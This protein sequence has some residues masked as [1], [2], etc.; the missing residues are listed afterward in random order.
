MER[1]GRESL[2]RHDWRPMRLR[3]HPIS[4]PYRVD[5]M[6][7]LVVGLDPAV[8]GVVIKTQGVVVGVGDLGEVAGGV[9]LVL[10]EVAA[11]VLVAGVPGEA[12]D[13]LLKSSRDRC[14]FLRRQHPNR[15]TLSRY[16]LITS[17]IQ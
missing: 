2:V 12:D 11:G 9:V 10:G 14:A 17:P 6:P 1:N 13:K 4:A 16:K 15:R 5:A 3:Q 7:G 8:D